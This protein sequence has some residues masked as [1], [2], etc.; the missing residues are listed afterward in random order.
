MKKLVYLCPLLFVF[1]KRGM[2]ITFRRWGEARMTTTTNTTRTK[3]ERKKKERI[4]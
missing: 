4:A 3:K 1:K 2:Y